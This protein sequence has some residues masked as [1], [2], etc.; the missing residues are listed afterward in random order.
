MKIGDLA[1]KNAASE[2][3]GVEERKEG[4][5]QADRE[6]SARRSAKAFG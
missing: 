2:G 4:R 6:A 5:F 1:K 3:S